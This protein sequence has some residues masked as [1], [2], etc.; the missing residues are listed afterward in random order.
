MLAGLLVLGCG[1]G[2]GFVALHSQGAAAPLPPSPRAGGPPASDCAPPRDGAS[3]A[4]TAPTGRDGT[5][6]WYALA[7]P[8]TWEVGALVR[9]SV[10]FGPGGAFTVAIGEVREPCPHVRGGTYCVRMVIRSQREG[11]AHS[12]MGAR[13]ELIPRDERIRM[14]KNIGR[15]S[16]IE[17]CV[18]HVDVGSSD[19]TA[20]DDVYEILGKSDRSVGRF[21]IRE[22]SEMEATGELVDGPC[23]ELADDETATFL[24]HA[25]S[26]AQDETV[27]ILV[28][29]FDPH[30]AEDGDEAKTGRGFAKDFAGSLADAAGK[31]ELSRVRV[32]YEPNERVT[33]DAGEASAQEQARAIGKHHAADVVVWGAMRC[34]TTSCA[35]PRFTVVTEN[36]LTHGSYRG[37][38]IWFSRDAS[39]GE[40]WSGAPP[41]DPVAL[42]SLIL[43]NVA[44]RAQRFGD[45]AYYLGRVKSGVLDP[46]D[47]F[48]RLANL[49]YA[50]YV[51]G[52]V[53]AS[54][55]WATLLRNGARRAKNLHFELEGLLALARGDEDRGDT[56]KAREEVETVT[57]T[58]DDKQ[59]VEA[60]ISLGELEAGEGH[61][62]LARAD[63]RQA[64]ELATRS[65]DKRGQAHASYQLAWWDSRSGDLDMARKRYQ[66]AVDIAKSIGDK[67]IESGALYDLGGIDARAGHLEA[68]RS[69]FEQARQMVAVT[70]DKSAEFEILGSLGELDARE[71][72]NDVARQHL[73]ASREVAKSIGGE[74]DEAT[75]LGALADLDATE[76]HFDAARKRL[77]N[78]LDILQ[79]LGNRAAQSA[80]LTTL[81]SFEVREGKID[82]AQT[83][84]QVALELAKAIENKSAQAR[85]LILIGDFDLQQGRFAEAQTHYEQCLALQDRIE[86]VDLAAVFRGLGVARW[87]QGD[88]DSAR[89]NLGKSRALE[90]STGNLEG[91]AASMMYLGQIESREGRVDAARELY[92]GALA[93][94]KT[95]GYT[96]GEASTLYSISGL[97]DG[98]GHLDAARGRLESARDM[99]HGIGDKHF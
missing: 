28:V 99:A 33:L 64:L 5:D 19:G 63:D 20:V 30:D 71:G 54:T 29:N 39:G 72:K 58:G 12:L 31:Q 60:M 49:A 92:A 32:R 23:A 36:A 94:F 95:T 25:A 96:A 11:E 61:A 38:D 85:V 62:D 2:S 24:E 40:R 26:D 6:E 7:L 43:G 90:Q 76:G 74:S 35:Q 93:N 52:Q 9:L 50:E 34:G 79:R 21:R 4:C 82:D 81:A 41:S 88:V 78:A 22:V 45:A 57:R 10:P 91:E 83:H 1:S 13:A 73:E 48:Q 70:G 56:Q 87:L 67:E 15:V 59:R 3:Y 51:R 86:K 18:A 46:A 84:Y 16:Q 44:F 53:D 65:G 77:G 14:G 27:S 17:S 69:R 75:A 68:A 89:S 66:D 37:A 97:D 42:A 8:E 80:M 55:R 47:D 98:Q